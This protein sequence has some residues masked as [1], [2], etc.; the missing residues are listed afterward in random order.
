MRSVFAAHGPSFERN[1][2]IE[3]FENVN[4]YPL[5]CD[6]LDIKCNPHNGSLKYFES[7]YRTS[8]CSK[9]QSI[10]NKTY[11]IFYFIFILTRLL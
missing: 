6:L 9:L 8:N 1:V 4:V 10:L 7:V 11:A 5:I 2:E 3:A